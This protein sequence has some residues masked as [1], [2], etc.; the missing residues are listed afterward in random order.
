MEFLMKTDS[1]MDVNKQRRECKT[2]VVQHF[3]NYFET[4][5]SQI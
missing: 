1:K 5:T 2:N 3:L 4:N